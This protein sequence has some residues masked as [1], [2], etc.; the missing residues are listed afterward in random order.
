MRVQG[1]YGLITHGDSSVDAS[2]GEQAQR[3]N[4]ATTDKWWQ[5]PFRECVGLE[6]SVQLRDL[7]KPHCNILPYAHAGFGNPKETVVNKK[8]L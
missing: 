6:N 3:S 4:E 2:L 7:S 8:E 5:T 1:Y